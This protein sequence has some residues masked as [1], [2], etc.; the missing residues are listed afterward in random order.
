MR[1][2]IIF[3]IFTS[4][5]F[6]SAPE[7]SGANRK[8]NVIVTILPQAEFVEKAGGEYVDVSVMVPRGTD[9]HT[10][11]PT[12]SQLKKAA[13]ADLYFK[14]G[15]GVEFELAWMD[16]IASLNKNLTIINTSEGVE[17]LDKDP[18]IWLSPKNAII[19][20]GS[21]RD[22]LIAKDPQRE[23]M[24][25][26]NAEAYIK[27]LSRLDAEIKEKLAHKQNRI[28]M[29]FHPSWGYFARDYDLKEI[30]IEIEGK[31]PTIAGLKKVIDEARETGVKEIFTS[32]QFSQRSAEV[33]AKE[34]NGRV[35]SVDP[36]SKNY[37]E[38]LKYIADILKKEID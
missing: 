28:F 14:L 11:E 19:M 27:E 4:I 8:T 31:E 37:V 32:P 25:Q 36:L 29:V 26:K 18:H 12:P 22:A 34:I 1:G 7:E 30:S 17:L 35:V 23:K 10:Y 2:K 5:I 6:C 21:I 33:V 3:L 15:S 20:V 9:P 16:K 24:Y 38:N 13:S